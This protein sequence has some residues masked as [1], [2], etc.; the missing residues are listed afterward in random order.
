VYEVTTEPPFEAG[1]AKLT[2]AER[3]PVAVATTEIGTVGAPTVVA[4]LEALD[5][6]ELPTEFVALTVNV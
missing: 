1:A 2:V 3:L 4:E 5:A 6:A